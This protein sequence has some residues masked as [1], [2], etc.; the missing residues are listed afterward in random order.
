[1]ISTDGEKAFDK[2]KPSLMI[3]TFRKLSTERNFV[4]LNEN[5]YEKTLVSIILNSEKVDVFPLKS[6]TRQGC[7]L[8]PILFIIILKVTTMQE[9]KKMSYVKPQKDTD[10]S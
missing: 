4:N 7:S 8:S 6:G 5:I 10:E 9:Q 2:I 3:K 1:M